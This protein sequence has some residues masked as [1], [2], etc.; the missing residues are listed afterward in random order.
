MECYPAIWESAGRDLVSA[1][2]TGN[3]EALG[4]Y[5]RRAQSEAALWAGRI[6]ASRSNPKVIE[7]GLP[8]LIQSRMILLALEKCNLAAATGKASGKIRFNRVNGCIVQNLLFEHDLV[9][10]PVSLKWFRFWWPLLNQKRFLMPLVQPKGIYCF[11]TRELIAAL[12]AMMH[13]LLCLEI[14]AGDGTL[15]RFL[16]D[17]GVDIRAT[18]DHSWSRAIQY[19]EEVSKCGAREALAQIKPQAVVCSWPPPGNA[20]ERHVF[21]T[22]SVVLYIVI[23]SRYRFASGNWDAYAAQDTFEWKPDASLSRLVLPPELDSSVLIFKR[24]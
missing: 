1:M 23:G 21:S 10:K 7:T 19:P 11:Y 24:K 16:R 15:A 9:R 17:A 14:A 4:D 8:R 3:A 2:E 22:S 6:R 12:A 20:F 18:D 13:G 5:A